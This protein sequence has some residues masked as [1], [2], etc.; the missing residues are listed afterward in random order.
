[1]SIVT[2]RKCHSFD[3]PYLAPRS[4]SSG[5]LGWLWRG[6]RIDR[7]GRGGRGHCRRC[8]GS[9]RC[10]RLGRRVVR[11]ERMPLR[12]L[13]TQDVGLLES[14][15][16]QAIHLQEV[17]STGLHSAYE[18]PRLP[19]GFMTMP[20]RR[21]YLSLALEKKRCESRD[22]MSVKQKKRVIIKSL[23]LHLMNV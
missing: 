20:R 22:E 1:M 13:Q 10:L 11:G 7:R 5:L 14:W 18:E 9:W 8:R 21:L 16:H 3:R 19:N 12:S 4:S 2:L 17:K 6:R 15:I 23:T